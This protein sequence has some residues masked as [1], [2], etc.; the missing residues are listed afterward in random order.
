L[1]VWLLFLTLNIQAHGQ[2]LGDGEPLHRVKSFEHLVE[3]LEPN[4]YV[5]L[6]SA[7]KL[8]PVRQLYV[9]RFELRF[10]S[11]GLPIRLTWNQKGHI[12]LNGQKIY[13][14][15]LR[16]RQAL[17][18]KI[19][20]IL[21]RSVSF[22]PL[23]I[24][25]PE[26]KADNAQL[27]EAL[28]LLINYLSARHPEL[29]PLIMESLVRT[30]VATAQAEPQ[31][32]TTRPDSEL[33]WDYTVDLAQLPARAPREPQVTVP[34][35]ASAPVTQAPVAG[36]VASPNP[37]ASNCPS[38]YSTA[39]CQVVELTNGHRRQHGLRPLQISTQCTRL[40]QSHASDMAR[41][42]F[43]SHT[44]P[45]LGSFSARAR[46]H[47]LTHAG[48][49]IARGQRTAQEAFNDWRSSPGHNQNMLGREFTHI[50][51][52]RVGNDWVQCF[53]RE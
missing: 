37:S 35:L 39:A 11:H 34:A 30:P 22:S 48:E 13:A 19:Q 14:H 26:L 46:A 38:S 53:S 17:S 20:E 50:G 41:T 10:T 16:S 21:G 32:E 33:V 23:Q 2:F 49:N 1:F 5:S 36:T 27:I 4:Y 52:A 42:G 51:V 3:N 45:N 29:A 18:L 9:G 31:R 12:T 8:T 47:N 6:P 43:F 40:A 7:I 25:I 44:S 28:L 24:L 15:H